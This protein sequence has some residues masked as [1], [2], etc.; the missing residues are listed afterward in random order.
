MGYLTVEWGTVEFGDTSMGCFYSDEFG[1]LESCRRPLVSVEYVR[2]SVKAKI[3]S[4][5]K[6]HPWGTAPPRDGR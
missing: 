5:K 1:G 6:E 4:W 2:E 3:A